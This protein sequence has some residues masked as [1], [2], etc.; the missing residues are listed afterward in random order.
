MSIATLD[1]LFVASVMDIYYA[2]K[3]IL[4]ALL[5]AMA[6][7]AD[8]QDLKIALERHRQE[9]QAQV[10]RIE[11][12]FELMDLPPRSRQSD[13]VDELLSQAKAQMDE[14]TDEKMLDAGVIGFAQAVGHYEISRYGTLIAWAK[15]LGRADIAALLQQSLDQEKNANQLLAEIATA[16][17][18]SKQAA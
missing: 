1:E 7:R 16:A 6:M 12:V 9:T 10:E 11:A 18:V 5:P 2:E 17:P 3:Q 14:I 15:A 13:A 4:K 8:R